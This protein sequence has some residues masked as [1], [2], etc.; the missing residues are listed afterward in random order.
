MSPPG[1]QG[2]ERFELSLPGGGRL[3]GD[4]LGGRA[5][6]YLFLHGL[7]SVRAGE[8]SSAL[9]LHARA[10]G[11]SCTRF[12]FRGHGESSG[13]IGRVTISELVDDTLA[14]LERVGPA[15]VVGSSL[16]GV[17]GALAAARAPERVA[18]LALLA[19]AF[20]LLRDLPRLLDA[21]GRLRTSD[22]RA[23]PVAAEV[24]ADAR[25]QDELAL[26]AR[27]PMPVML[28]HGTGDEVVP[29]SVSERFFAA[30]PHSRKDLWIVAG[31][32]HRLSAAANAIWQRFDR[33]AG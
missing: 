11:R 4:H 1:Q 31:G 21:H 30:I 19:P 25:A 22:G 14:V 20:G 15:R 7:G 16:G 33:F 12:D 10:G 9:F 6:G 29:V 24:L 5:P 3:V 17:V 27:L 2:H 8:K 28:V 18:A 13:T 32:D 26:P 23:F